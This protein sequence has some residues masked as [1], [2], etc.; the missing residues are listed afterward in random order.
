ME[1]RN[2]YDGIEDYAVRIIKHK[3]RQLIG[4][5]GFVE[6]DR[7]DL[8]QEM[9]LDLLHRLPKYDSNKA[10]RNT[11]VA[12]IVEHKVS[13]IIEERSAG[14]RDWRLCTAS[15]NDKL[16]FGESGSV[17]RLEVYDMDEY[18]RQTGQ[19]SRPSS[20]RMELSIDL[21]STISSLPPEL[22]D[23]CERLQTMNVSEI[24]RD[25]GIPRGTLYDRIKELRSLFED[26]GL[27]EYL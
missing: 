12:R 11:F 13:I 25:T 27:R 14:K 19:L 5:R 22:S 21:R 10:Q 16:D 26:R 8:E 18:L 1:F 9:M 20:E 4:S 7:D 15:M 2:R 3:A 6:S 24:S 23:L 17:E